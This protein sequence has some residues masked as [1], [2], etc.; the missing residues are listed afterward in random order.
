MRPKENEKEIQQ[1]YEDFRAICKHKAGRNILA[2]LMRECGFLELSTMMNRQ[3]GEVVKA[4]TEQN[5]GR[6]SVYLDIRPYI[7][8]EARIEIENPLP[9]PKVETPKIEDEEEWP[10]KVKRS[11][12]TRRKP[13]RVT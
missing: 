11:P 3:T 5:E 12:M 2:W 13:K 1:R 6:R 7:P 4:N 8:R 10:E 9:A